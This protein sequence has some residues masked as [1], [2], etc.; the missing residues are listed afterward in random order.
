MVQVI[1]LKGDLFSRTQGLI[2]TDV[3]ADV[4]V[5]IGGQGSGGA[6]ISLEFAKLGLSQILMDHDRIEVANVVRHVA[7]LSDVGR[8]K[9]KVMAERIRDKNPY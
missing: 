9:T 2:E 7:G 6:P 5:L 4:R 8:H 1:P 3:L